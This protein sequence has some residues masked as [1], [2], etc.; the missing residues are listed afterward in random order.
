MQDNFAGYRILAWCFFPPQYFQYFTPLSSCLHG[1]WVEVGYIS[2]CC[3][4]ISQVFFPLASFRICSLS[5]IFH[6]LK[7]ICL[8]VFVCLFILAFIL[9]VVLWVSYICGLVSELNLEKVSIFKYFFF[10]FLII[11]TF[12]QYFLYFL[13]ILR[14]SFK[15]YFRF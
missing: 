2:H 8:G 11:S 7:M 6:I 14:N 15:I 4:F 13:L 9:L 10:A 5:L 12:I 3:S 1:F